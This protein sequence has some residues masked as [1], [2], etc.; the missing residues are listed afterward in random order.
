MGDTGVDDAGTEVVALVLLAAHQLV[1]QIQQ[2][3]R[4]RGFKDVRPAHGFAFACLASGGATIVDLAAHLGVTKQAA[5]QLVQQLLDSGYVNREAAPDDGRA[6]LITLTERGRSCTRAADDAAR[7]TVD[8]WRGK[9]S[10]EALTT[11]RVALAAFV[12][13]GPVRPAW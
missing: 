2:G 11:L 5:S 8:Q 10:P 9:T 7:H 12:V 1:E 4:D 13:R 3:V 6:R